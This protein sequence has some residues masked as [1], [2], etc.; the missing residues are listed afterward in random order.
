MFVLCGNGSSDVFTV[1]MHHPPKH[2]MHTHTHTYLYVLKTYL[3]SMLM[4]TLGM[5]T[6]SST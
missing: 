3:R 6:P 1:L 5:W 2:D 4:I